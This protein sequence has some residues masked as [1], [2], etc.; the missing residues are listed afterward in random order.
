MFYSFGF[1]GDG[2]THRNVPSV[3]AECVA[4]PHKHGKPFAKL[5]TPT[6]KTTA[7]NQIAK[8]S[9]PQATNREIHY[10]KCIGALPSS[11][12]GTQERRM[13][14]KVTRNCKLRLCHANLEILC[15]SKNVVCSKNRSPKIAV[16]GVKLRSFMIVGPGL[17][18]LT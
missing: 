4:Q 3:R 11:Y 16:R 14:T 7:S 12:L 13:N 10:S 15:E 9:L 6:F 5:G 18:G 8:V 2:Q 17:R 1:P